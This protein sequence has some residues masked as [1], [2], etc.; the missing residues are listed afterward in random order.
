MN[1]ESPS[2]EREG[3]SLERELKRQSRRRFVLRSTS[4]F[5]V[6]ELAERIITKVKADPARVCFVS[7][8]FAPQL[9]GYR[10]RRRQANRWHMYLGGAA[11]IGGVST[12]A[13]AAFD[14]AGT[15]SGRVAVA[16]LGLLSGAAAGINQFTRP[17]RRATA[18][19]RAALG[20]EREGW[21]FL[22]DHPPYRH[23]DSDGSW[24]LFVKRVVEEEAL[25][26]VVLDTPEDGAGAPSVAARE[27]GDSAAQRREGAPGP[28]KPR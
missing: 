27:Q 8:N 15:Q 16:I 4:I 12:S 24:R 6:P 23:D 2:V 5:G 13:L 28:A 14:A 25:A 20:L 22:F 10:Q 26:D 11:V 1:T 19:R 9:L 7:A 3:E 18:Y 17:A 21:F